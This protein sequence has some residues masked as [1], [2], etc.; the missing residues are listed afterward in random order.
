MLLFASVCLSAC[1][2][3]FF[4]SVCMYVCLSTG[5][6]VC[7]SVCL[8]CVNLSDGFHSKTAAH[9]LRGPHCSV[10]DYRTRS[11]S[12]RF[13]T[14]RPSHGK[15]EPFLFRRPRL[16]PCCL[17]HLPPPDPPSIRDKEGIAGSPPQPSTYAADLEAALAENARLR[18]RLEELQEMVDFQA[19]AATS[20]SWRGLGA[21]AGRKGG[22]SAAAAGG[23]SIAAASDA[24]LRGQVAQL[25]R[26]VRLQWCAVD[27][28]AAVNQE[29]GGNARCAMSDLACVMRAF[30][31]ISFPQAPFYG[32]STGHEQ[33]GEDGAGRERRTFC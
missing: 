27:A 7:L 17:V 3:I 14:R 19:P 12:R 20:R 33:K 26:Q 10:F 25:R 21:H 1:L 22:P 30:C 29:V 15:P 6:P 23:G 11:G 8:R 5:L 28:S 31:L 2:S 32:K 24:I 18:Q 13:Q 16:P 9:G 4:M